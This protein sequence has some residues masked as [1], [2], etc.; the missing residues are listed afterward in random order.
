MNTLMNIIMMQGYGFYVWG[1]VFIT[2]AI[3]SGNFIYAK[4]QVKKVKQ[5]KK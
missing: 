2:I 1:S 5:G 3:L 4:H